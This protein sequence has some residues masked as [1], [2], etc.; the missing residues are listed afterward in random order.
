[1][2]H[3]NWTFLYS[4]S[5]VPALVGVGADKQSQALLQFQY[6][7]LWDQ[8]S[9]PSYLEK[10]EKSNWNPLSESPAWGE[11]SFPALSPGSLCMAPLCRLGSL[12]GLCLRGLQWGWGT[13]PLILTWHS[14]QPEM[15]QMESELWAPS[16]VFL[17]LS[18]PSE[19][20]L[21]EVFKCPASLLA[22]LY[23][24]AT[25]LTFWKSLRS[26]TLWQHT[27]WSYFLSLA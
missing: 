12:S 9:C 21:T 11:C 19:I 3:P 23:H 10:G 17:I 4:C 15:N 24:T 13:L 27:M 8:I 14:R 2:F 7:K 18:A 22:N 1:M 20:H 6:V 26:C 16:P 5:G 25:V